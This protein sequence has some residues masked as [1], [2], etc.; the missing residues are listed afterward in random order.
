MYDMWLWACHD[1]H[2]Q[3]KNF[4]RALQW[5]GIDIW[6]EKARTDIPEE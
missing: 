1:S 3:S 2:S 4:T 5:C 6:E